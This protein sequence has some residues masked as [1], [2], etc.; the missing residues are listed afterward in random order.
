MTSIKNCYIINTVL[1]H[2]LN[3]KCITRDNLQMLKS[4]QVTYV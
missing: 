2:S 1:K 4:K 3:N